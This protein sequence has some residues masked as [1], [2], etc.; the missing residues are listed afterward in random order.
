MAVTASAARAAPVI[1]T[2]VPEGSVDAGADVLLEP[3]AG[4][5]LTVRFRPNGCDSPTCEVLAM[6]GTEP[7]GPA[8]STVTPV[9]AATVQSVTETPLAAESVL[10]AYWAYQ[11]DSICSAAWG[12][13]AWRMTLG[14][15]G[16]CDTDGWC[17]GT[18]SRYGRVADINCGRS[19]AGYTISTE[20]CAFHADP[21]QT[22]LYA[23]YRARLRR[24]AR[25]SAQRGSLCP[26]ALPARPL[27]GRGGLT[28]TSGR[29]S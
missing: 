6:T 8:T 7:A 25:V 18:R 2:P 16:W 13:W 11:D 14:S 29:R 1:K 28:A 17:W 26:P 19:S 21:S 3:A 20:D 12:C 22:D 15:S 27:L 5:S 9:G 10:F 24:R 4:T 23:S